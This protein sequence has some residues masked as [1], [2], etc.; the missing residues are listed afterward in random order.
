MAVDFKAF[1]EFTRQAGNAVENTCSSFAQN[2]KV[3]MHF[4]NNA[5]SAVD[6]SRT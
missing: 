6:F 2:A 3:Q 5:N 1:Y 4:A